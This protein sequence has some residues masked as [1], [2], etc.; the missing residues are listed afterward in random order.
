[1]PRK[2]YRQRGTDEFPKYGLRASTAVHLTRLLILVGL[3]V[4]AF[5]LA[6]GC[7]LFAPSSPAAEDAKKPRTM[8]L[9]DSGAG[10]FNRT[11]SAPFVRTVERRL[12]VWI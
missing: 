9:I 2:D 7:L 5:V 8:G 6:H 4:G 3:L 10:R 1:M 12:P 11:V